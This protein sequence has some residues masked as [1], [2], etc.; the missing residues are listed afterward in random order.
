MAEEFDNEVKEEKQYVLPGG[1]GGNDKSVF[2]IWESIQNHLTP[3]YRKRFFIRRLLCCIVITIIWSSITAGFMPGLL[4]NIVSLLLGVLSFVFRHY[5][6]WS[7]QGG[8]IDN[9]LSGYIRFGG[10]ISLVFRTIFQHV[11][12][13][14]WI[15][16]IAPLSGYVTWQKAVKK[17][18]VLY[19]ETKL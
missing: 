8:H 19:I 16:F 2:G 15:T 17:D 4:S 7:Y 10:F 13:Y 3:E 14:L 12:V 11:L 9:F 18:K 5:S 1:E 6:Y